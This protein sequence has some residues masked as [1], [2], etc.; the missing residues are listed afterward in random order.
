METKWYKFSVYDI[1][2]IAMLVAFAVIL[3]LPGLKIKLTAGAGSISITMVPLI[4]LALRF[5]IFKSFV[6]IGLV[7]GLITNLIDGYG[8]ITFPLDYL[9]AYGSLSLV[10]LFRPQKMDKLTVIRILLIAV[11]IIVGG[12]LRIFFSTLSGVLLYQYTFIASFLYNL[13]LIGIS[14]LISLG[15]V[16]LTY[17]LMHKHLQSI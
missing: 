6:G 5:N 11:G 14:L 2:E 9:L 8:F 16:V 10:S 7:Y 3:D 1:T 17:P 13:P 12:L 15:I 4:L